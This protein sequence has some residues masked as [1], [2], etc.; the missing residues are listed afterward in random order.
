MWHFSL[1]L[2]FVAGRFQPTWILGVLALVYPTWLGSVSCQYGTTRI[3]AVAEK[4][5]S[6]GLFSG[7]L[8]LLTAGFFTG[9][10]KCRPTGQLIVVDWMCNSWSFVV[11][12]RLL[13]TWCIAFLTKLYALWILPICIAVL[14][15]RLRA[16]S[17]DLR[18][19]RVGSG[20]LRLRSSR[21]DLVSGRLRKARIV[22][23]AEIICSIG[24]VDLG[25]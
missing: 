9:A 13:A 21:F 24:R 6:R 16:V 25:C 2:G 23:C 1:G 5:P 20:P 18:K 8:M 4:L 19:A 14:Y 17:P 15:F 22:C 11:R 3:F 12:R 7:A 10:A